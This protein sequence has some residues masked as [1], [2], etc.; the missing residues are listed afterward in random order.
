MT[1]ITMMIPS[2]PTV[3]S[4]REVLRFMRLAVRD[5]ADDAGDEEVRADAADGD[6]DRD[7]RER[8]LFFLAVFGKFQIAHEA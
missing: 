6:P 3:V 4:S 5:D 8:G 7:A 1:A 2:R